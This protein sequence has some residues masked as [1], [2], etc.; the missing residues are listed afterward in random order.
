MGNAAEKLDT[1]PQAYAS[2][3]V[4]LN[5]V[6]AAMAE[7]RA[8]HG[9]VPDYTTKEGYERG[10]ASLKELTKY[11]TG[12]DKARLAITKPHRDFI[13]QVNQYAKGLIGEIE[14]L[15]APHRDAKREVDE[16][17]Q[18]KKE[19]RIA[20]LQQRLTKEVTSYL[21]TAVGLDSSG[22]ADLIEAAEGIDTEGYFDITKEAEDEKAR[23]IRELTAQHASALEQERMAA[24]QAELAEERR[25]LQIDQAIQAIRMA[26]LDMMG[27]PA[28]LIRTKIAEI[29]YNRPETADYGDRTQEASQAHEQALQQLR[30]M[31]QQAE[32]LEAAKA[33]EPPEPAEESQP[34]PHQPIDTSRLNAAAASYT[35][36]IPAEEQADVGELLESHQAASNNWDQAFED[37]VS[38]GL[39][40]DDAQALLAEIAHGGIRHV[41]FNQGDA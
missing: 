19:E 26:P 30:M 3:L 36:P 38:F 17:E 9:T 16:A 27:K 13:D 6:E 23:V 12:T 8:K 14:Q 34:A 25:K 21:D 32:Q 11:R 24:E 33:E 10:K 22:L 29:E 2:E 40:V 39:D 18:R 1:P 37:L 20:R 15:E 4:E 28:V 35:P 5:R 31:Q 7:L 41:A